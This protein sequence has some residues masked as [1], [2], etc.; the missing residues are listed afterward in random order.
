[1]DAFLDW[2]SPTIFAP[3]GLVLAGEGGWFI[4]EVAAHGVHLSP[5]TIE[6]MQPETTR[7]RAKWTCETPPGSQDSGACS[8]LTEVWYPEVVAMVP[9]ALAAIAAALHGGR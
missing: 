3:A 2:E 4:G 5:A 6:V 1:M 8:Y 9:E 7:W